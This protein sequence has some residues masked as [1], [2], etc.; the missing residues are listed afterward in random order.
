MMNEQDERQKAAEALATVRGHQERTRRATRLPW[1]VYVATFVLSA[2]AMALND[3]V[4]LTGAK[5]VA[6]LI[7]VALVVVLLTGFVTGSAP[8]SRVRGVQRRQSFVPWVFGVVAIIAGL[9]AWLISRYGTGFVNGVA[10]ATGLR[11]Y[12]NTVAGVVYGAAFTALFAVS[13]LLIA[14]SQRRTNE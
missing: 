5:L 1:W 12:P 11:D 2:G 14:A 9:G 3:F 6:V 7:M 8:L 13:Q 4:S 10:D